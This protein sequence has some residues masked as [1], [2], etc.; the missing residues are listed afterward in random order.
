ML[1][2]PW[3]EEIMAVVACSH[4]PTMQGQKS[5]NKGPETIAPDQGGYLETW[6]EPDLKERTGYSS[7]SGRGGRDPPAGML[8]SKVK[9]NLDMIVCCNDDHE[10]RSFSTDTN[11]R[12]VMFPGEIA[13]LE[14]TEQGRSETYKLDIVRCSE[15]DQ[16]V[17]KHGA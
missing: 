10:R 5:E 11:G 1:I 12:S 4:H 8:H 9:K 7:H 17:H 16:D 14:L 15:G 13:S 3:M 6:Q 2:Q